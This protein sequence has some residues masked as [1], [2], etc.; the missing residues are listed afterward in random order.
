MVDKWYSEA[1]EGLCGVSVLGEVGVHGHFHVQPNYSVEVVLCCRWG[2]VNN[3]NN[4]NKTMNNNNNI[5]NNNN[6][7]LGL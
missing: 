3:T 6:N 7:F 4:H 2:C 5:N 1:P